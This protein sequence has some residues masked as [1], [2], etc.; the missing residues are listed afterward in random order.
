M[1]TI[2]EKGAP[3]YVPWVPY[4]EP[5]N[6]VTIQSELGSAGVS[7]AL[8]G[9]QPVS[10]GGR[11]GNILPRAETRRLM[12]AGRMPARTGRMPALPQSAS[13]QYSPNCAKKDR[14]LRG[15]ALLRLDIWSA[16]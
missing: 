5:A 14:P 6:V 7:A 16:F 12:L 11:R 3:G 4:R 8:T 1:R 15:P 2:K 13:Q 10:R 9:F